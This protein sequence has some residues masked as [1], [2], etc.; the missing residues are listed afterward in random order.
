MGERR[1]SKRLKSFLRGFVYFDKRRGATSCLIRDL[2][3]GGARI[4]LSEAV[5]LPDNL[6]L[7]IPQ[8]D[9]SF[10]AR[11]QW[12]R[13]DEIGLALTMEDRRAASEPDAEEMMKRVALLEGE[14][15]SLRKVLKKLKGEGRDDEAA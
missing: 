9:Q 7:H 11:V 13:G 4:I 15:T 10:R 12:R 8:K 5:T 3:S 6:N 2:S 14:I 1:T